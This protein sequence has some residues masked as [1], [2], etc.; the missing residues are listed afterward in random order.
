ML[1][2]LAEKLVWSGHEPQ[3]R[4]FVAEALAGYRNDV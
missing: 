4:L 1:C 3:A 2:E